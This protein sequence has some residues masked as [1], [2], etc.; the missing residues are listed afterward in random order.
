MFQEN[1]RLPDRPIS[2]SDAKNLITR[3]SPSFEAN[4]PSDIHEPPPLRGS[5]FHY[6]LQ[7][8]PK[9]PYRHKQHIRPKVWQTCFIKTHG[10]TYRNSV[11]FIPQVTLLLHSPQEHPARCTDS[12]KTQCTVCAVVRDSSVGTATL[13]GCTVRGSNPGEG[14]DFSHPS[15]PALGSTQH[16]IQWV[17]SLSWV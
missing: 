13:T 3:T 1:F 17:P 8:N 10:V 15:R 16:R 6:I 11:I 14:R 2:D 5:K 9:L 7:K 4:I 12:C